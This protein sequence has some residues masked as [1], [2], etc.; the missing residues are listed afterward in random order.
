[1]VCSEPVISIS[2]TFGTR[3]SRSIDAMQLNLLNL[4]DSHK[5]VG[6]VVFTYGGLSG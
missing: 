2:S 5:V 1:M 4:W 6:G 3:L